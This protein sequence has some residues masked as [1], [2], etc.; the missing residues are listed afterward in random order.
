MIGGIIESV[1]IK[2]DRVVIVVKDETYN[3]RQTRTLNKC[4]K[5]MC[6]GTGDSIWWQGRSY[7]WTPQESRRLNPGKDRDIKID[8]A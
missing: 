4:P 8:A 5:S 2:E 1:D 7:Y 3:D 6:V